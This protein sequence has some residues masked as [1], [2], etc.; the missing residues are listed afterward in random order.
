MIIN[1]TKCVILPGMGREFTGRF[2]TVHEVAPD[3]SFASKIKCRVSFDDSTAK[4]K[5]TTW[6]DYGHLISVKEQG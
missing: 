1:P 5:R 2:V 4:K 6:F 3:E